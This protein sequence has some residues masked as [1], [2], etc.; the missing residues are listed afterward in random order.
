MT[1]STVSSPETNGIPMPPWRDGHKLNEVAFSH[2][3]LEEHPMVSV[4]DTFFTL[5]GRIDDEAQLRQEIYSM[6]S[7]Y[8]TG[9]VSKRVHDIVEVLRLQCYTPSLPLHTM[10]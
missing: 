6:I 7:P 9:A 4:G 8:V 2:A 5:D 3:F 1:E 10:C